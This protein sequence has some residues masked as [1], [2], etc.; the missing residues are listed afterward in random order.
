MFLST[1]SVI[2]SAVLSICY[3][4]NMAFYVINRQQAPVEPEPVAIVMPQHHQLS[5]H[6]TVLYD[7]NQNDA[8]ECC[9]P[10]STPPAIHTI[11][12]LTGDVVF[13]PHKEIYHNLFFRPP[14]SI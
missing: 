6:T 9:T 11:C 13:T 5:Q 8:Q 4:V 12:R 3:L 10:Q 14:P 7:Q 2:I 1:S